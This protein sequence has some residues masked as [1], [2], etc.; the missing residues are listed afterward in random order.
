MSLWR[1]KNRHNI[2]KNYHFFLI[3]FLIKSIYL[4]LSFAT[5]F[6]KIGWQ[7]KKFQGGQNDPPPPLGSH[8]TIFSLGF[9]GL[10][11]VDIFPQKNQI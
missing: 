5:K 9:L 2:V 6:V 10:R 7:I 11:K 3:F 4:D 8:V 1:H